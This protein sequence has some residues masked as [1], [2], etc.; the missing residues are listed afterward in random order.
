MLH[1]LELAF[2]LNLLQQRRQRRCHI[3]HG[4]WIC[5]IAAHAVRCP[6]I[7]EVVFERADVCVAGCWNCWELWK[8]VYPIFSVRGVVRSDEVEQPGHVIHHFRLRSRILLSRFFV[9]DMLLETWSRVAGED[10]YAYHPRRH[11]LL[12]SLTSVLT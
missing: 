3:G 2:L 6:E 10:P 4:V 12:L 9:H 11:R 8:I 1:T 5:C 7:G